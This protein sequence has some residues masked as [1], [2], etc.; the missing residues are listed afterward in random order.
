MSDHQKNILFWGPQCVYAWL[1]AFVVSTFEELNKHG[2]KTTYF[3]PPINEFN[4][5][6]PLNWQ[7]DF[8]TSDYDPDIR[9]IVDPACSVLHVINDDRASEALKPVFKGQ[10]PDIIVTRTHGH[11]YLKKLFPDVVILTMADAIGAPWYGR[12]T[13]CFA[14]TEDEFFYGNSFLSRH[15]EQALSLD[16]PADIAEEGY[17]LMNSQEQLDARQQ[18]EI[19]GVFDTLRNKYSKIYTMPVC[20]GMRETDYVNYVY[21][22][23]YMTQCDVIYRFLA[24]SDENSALIVTS[25]PFTPA[26]DVQVNL[27]KIFAETDR[28]IIA[29]DLEV[30]AKVFTTANIMP[31]CDGMMCWMS[32]AYWHA[33]ICEKP[34]F[35]YASHDIEFC[36]PYRDI[37]EWLA[38]TKP[39]ISVEDVLKLFYWSV[40]RYRIR[41]TD[42]L[43][44][45]RILTNF[46]NRPYGENGLHPA[47]NMYDWLDS[48]T[49][50]QKHFITCID[51][52]RAERG[53]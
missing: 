18:Q 2:W 35:D 51:Q 29:D 37:D 38:A 3:F 46:L 12:G 26:P 22:Q 7:R 14:L 28:I 1:P 11:G 42:T 32:K 50:Y 48:E 36:D 6:V 9:V 16:I 45:N 27:M 4:L 34:L 8:K 47:A 21:D 19:S 15:R 39:K 31:H 5:G 33:L 43:Q 53:L 25:H 49:E 44:L 23:Q 41:T 30:D 20:A 17:R 52:I 10:T 24:H 40:T 13:A